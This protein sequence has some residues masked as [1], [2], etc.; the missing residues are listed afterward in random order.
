M[1]LDAWYVD[2]WYV[3]VV[4]RLHTNRVNRL[5]TKRACFAAPALSGAAWGERRCVGR[6]ARYDTVHEDLNGDGEADLVYEDRNGARAL[7]RRHTHAKAC[8][9]SLAAAALPA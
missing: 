9:V 3:A 8:C 2:A 1:A 6:A 7:A 5:H 4:N